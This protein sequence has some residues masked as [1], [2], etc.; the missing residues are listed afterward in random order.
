MYYENI[1]QIWINYAPNLF[2]DVIIIMD[3]FETGLWLIAQGLYWAFFMMVLYEMIRWVFSDTHI[4]L[5]G[6]QFPTRN[7]GWRALKYG[8]VSSFWLSLFLIFI[9]VSLLTISAWDWLVH[10]RL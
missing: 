9:G 10:F 5:Q 6:W 2:T 8:I 3:F 7:K 4:F 1:I